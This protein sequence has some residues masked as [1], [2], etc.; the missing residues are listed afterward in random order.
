MR[1]IVGTILVLSSLLAGCE[2]QVDRSP[3]SI[4][5]GIPNQPSSALLHIAL[6]QGFFTE[7]GLD[8][9]PHYYASGKRALL[10]GYVSGEID[11]LSTADAPFVLK[12]S[13]DMPE[14]K[15]LASIYTTDN[16]NRIVAR[17]DVGIS[18]LSDLKGKRVATQSNSAVHYF[19]H[20]VIEEQQLDHTD[21][22]VSFMPADQLPLSLAGGQIDA[23]SMREPYVSQARELLGDDSVIVLDSPGTYVQSELLIARDTI[24]AKQPE[25]AE[26]MLSALIKAERFALDDAD[27][28]ITVV[29]K[30]LSTTSDAIAV[31]WQGFD[32]SVRLNQA[33]LSQLERMSQWIVLEV[34][35]EAIPPNFLNS[36][37]SAP[38]TKVAPSAVSLVR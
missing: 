9:T 10:D 8:V 11:Y 5:L 16:L 18:S 14:L 20:S 33:L 36:I 29:S 35:N 1:F 30:A 6:A 4:N 24:H 38:L 23:F 26:R 19:L 7:E 31:N 34:D 27:A 15:V 37:D 32:Y 22:S 13:T 17:K 21:L 3:I 28:A 2:R 12:V 25:V